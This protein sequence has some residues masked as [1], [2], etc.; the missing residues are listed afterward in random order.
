M[1]SAYIIIAI[2]V[3]GALA[4]VISVYL[5]K[6]HVHYHEDDLKQTIDEFF[7]KLGD[8]STSERA[9]W[10]A[11][12]KKYNCSRKDTLYLVGLAR[13]RGFIKQVDGKVTRG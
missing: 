4:I 12:Q 8:D 7:D 10:Q 1:T 6:K 2:A 13:K 5:H 11:I 9:I 3:V